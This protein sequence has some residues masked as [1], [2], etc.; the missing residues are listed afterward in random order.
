GLR[1]GDMI[2]A[3]NGHDVRTYQDVIDEIRHSAPG[4]RLEITIA[5]GERTES[6]E[7]ILESR[8]TTTRYEV[9]KPALESK[10][11]NVQPVPDDGYRY[12]RLRRRGLFRRGK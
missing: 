12:D 6:A 1:R 2:V 8:P 7:V 11:R 4:D 5:I 10:F 3:V 9:A